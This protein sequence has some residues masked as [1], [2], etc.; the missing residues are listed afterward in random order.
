MTVGIRF[1]GLGTTAVQ[2]IRLY[3][4]N[5]TV[6][7]DAVDNLQTRLYAAKGTNIMSRQTIIPTDYQVIRSARGPAVVL[8]AI[9]RYGPIDYFGL[10]E[11]VYGRQFDPFHLFDGLHHVVRELVAAGLIELEGAEP[12]ILEHLGSSQLPNA[13][14]CF[15]IAPGFST[16]QRLLGF[17][18]S[19]FA[20]EDRQKIR[21][22]PVFGEPLDV[23]SGLHT[24][25]MRSAIPDVFVIM[26][27]RDDLEHIFDFVKEAVHD[28]GLDCMRGDSF[29]SSETIIR[30][31]WSAIFYCK[32]C[33]ADCTG[34]NP[35]VFYETGI[36]DTLGRPCIL[37]AQSMDDIPFDVAHRRV[38][39]YHDS[40]QGMRDLQKKLVKALAV[41]L[42]SDP[43][44]DIDSTRDM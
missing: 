20:S 28:L 23:W 6:M 1:P 26:P 3:P 2:S 16:L 15:R 21:I 4:R 40:Y 19:E 27:F 18:L 24:D 13:K 36:A 8:W 44:S 41:E 31:V 39:I 34:K 42:K 30:E 9:S 32:A 37:I 5:P 22:D 7:T 12:A 17:T 10:F 38:L 14:L 35:N 25:W 33:I 29:Y 11:R 43:N